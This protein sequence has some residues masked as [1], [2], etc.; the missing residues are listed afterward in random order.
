VLVAHTC[1]PSSSG[2]R[3]QEKQSLKPTWA[4]SLRDPIFEKTHHKKELVE[5]L[6]VKVMSLNPST[7]KKKKNA[8]PSACW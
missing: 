6:K 2:G 8:F 7:T 3:D 5:W 1:N 4:N